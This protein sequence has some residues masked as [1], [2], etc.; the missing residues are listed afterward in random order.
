MTI[1]EFKYTF[2]EF[3]EGTRSASRSMRII[4]IFGWVIIAFLL[5]S[6][7]AH[8]LS[9]DRESNPPSP[10]SYL[11]AWLVSV[12]WVSFP[13]TQAWLVWRGTPSV[14]EVVRCWA[15]E[16]SFRLQTTNSDTAVKW[17]ALIKFRETRKFFLIYPSKRICYLIPKRAFADESQVKEF[18]ELLDRKINQRR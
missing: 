14:K 15:D 11:I 5:F 9:L 4:Q 18:R 10:S 16:E 6:H 8:Y 13:L 12:F 17:P 2:R 1:L 7:L 3:L